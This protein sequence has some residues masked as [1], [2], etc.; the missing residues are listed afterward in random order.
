[1]TY[2]VVL[3]VCGDLDELDILDLVEG[4]DV[5][6]AEMDM[7]DGDS[8]H[9]VTLYFVDKNELQKWLEECYVGND[10]DQVEDILESAEETI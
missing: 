6:I 9:E 3:P 4:Y 2:S 7:T 10:P 8:D 5:T 1:M